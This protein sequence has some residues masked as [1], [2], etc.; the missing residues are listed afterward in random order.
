MFNLGFCCPWTGKLQHPCLLPSVSTKPSI[1]SPYSSPPKLFWMDSGE[2]IFS[3][4]PNSVI[5]IKKIKMTFEITN[6]YFLGI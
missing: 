5:K 3:T 1:K 4:S 2:K 6:I